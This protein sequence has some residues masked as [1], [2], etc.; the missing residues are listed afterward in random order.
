MTL[1][2]VVLMAALFGGCDLPI[3]PAPTATPSPSPTV[4]PSATPT[5]LPPTA[6]PPT[7]T[8]T[9]SPTQTP[10]P[11][12]T[13]RPTASVMP[14]ATVT[15][16]PC[17]I[18]ALED[19]TVYVRPDSEAPVFGKM[20]QDMR[21]VA[22]AR[23]GD[24]WIGFEPGIAQAPNV[25]VFRLRWVPPEADVRLEGGCDDLPEV[26]GPPAGVC[27]TMPMDETEVYAEPDTGATVIATL[28][29]GD[30]AAILAIG[31]MWAQVDLSVGNLD[32]ESEGW[33]DALTLN[34]NGPCEALPTPSP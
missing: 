8:S 32:L 31:E 20:E 7:A 29:P 17:E 16:E 13:R 1:L 21:L 9:V 6:P 26:V 25:G 19:V 12:V 30:Y 27:F 15:A 28:V 11:T 24:G 34:L 33:V 22:E 14:T 5:A 18:V 3:W 23:T 10:S 4:T 2:G